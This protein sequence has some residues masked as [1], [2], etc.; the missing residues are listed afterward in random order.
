MDKGTDARNFLLGNVI[1]LR[2]GY[3]GVVNR[4]QHDINKNRAIKDAL[5]FEESFFRLNPVYHGL[6][7]CC[8]IPQLAKRLNQ[9]LVQHIK[10]VLPGLKSR[11]NA[12]LVAVAKEHAA[13]GDVPESKGFEKSRE[14]SNIWFYFPLYFHWP[15]I[16]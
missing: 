5:A 8:G 15:S 9:I 1:P 2:L 16:Y 11:I 14:H 6:S 12:Q 3:V 4:S 13:F 10:A 7:H